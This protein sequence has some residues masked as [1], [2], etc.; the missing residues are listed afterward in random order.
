MSTLTTRIRAVLLVAA[1]A[2]TGWFALTPGMIRAQGDDDQ[3]GWD[4]C[5]FADDGEFT[6]DPDSEHIYEGSC[7]GVDCYTELE[8]CCQMAN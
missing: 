7:E 2:M 1:F 6:C 4:E 5:M 8:D 3:D